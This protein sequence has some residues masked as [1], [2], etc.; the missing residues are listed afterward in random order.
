LIR[1]TLIG[2]IAIAIG[3]ASDESDAI[4]SLSVNTE[5]TPLVLLKRQITTH[6]TGGFPD[7][8]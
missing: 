7:P 2:E 5:P 4:G 3:D 1:G 8:L 6:G